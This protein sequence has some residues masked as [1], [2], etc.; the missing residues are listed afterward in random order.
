[1]SKNNNKNNKVVNTYEDRELSPQAYFNKMKSLKKNITDKELDDIYENCLELAN[2]YNIT[3]QIRALRKILFCMESIGKEKQLVDMGIVTFIYRDDLDFYIDEVAKDKSKP[4]KIIELE[5]YEREIPDEI[6][7]VIANTKNIFD[8]M[9]VVYTDYTKK[10]ERVIAEN[11]RRKDPILFGTFQSVKD[12]VCID[13]F[14]YLGDWIDEY[15]DLTLDKM[16]Q[17]TE[18]RGRNII[19]TIQTPQDIEQLKEYIDTHYEI[20]G[21]TVGTFVKK[22]D[23]DI[24]KEEI[25]SK[26]IFHN[27]KTFFIRKD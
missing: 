15:C 7:E 1:M 17:Q 19:R 5:R 26:N 9:Y 21:K 8:Q 23:A 25:K 22:A 24:N 10:E 16:I 11:R 12:K 4:I 14:Y 18:K 2:K 6:V 13:R 27:I 3:G 20:Q